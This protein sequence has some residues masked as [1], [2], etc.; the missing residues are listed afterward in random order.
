M[1]YG[2][3]GCQRHRYCHLYKWIRVLHGSVNRRQ[4]WNCGRQDLELWP[5]SGSWM[6]VGFVE[7]V[8]AKKECSDHHL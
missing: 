4:I 3:F 2:L 5:P 7:D 1:M 8:E 6:F